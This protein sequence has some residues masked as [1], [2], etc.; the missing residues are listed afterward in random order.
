LSFVRGLAFSPDGRRL[1]SADDS[2]VRIW[3]TSTGKELLTLKG[4]LSFVRGLAFSPDGRRL[5]SGSLDRTVRIWDASTGKELLT[6]KGH[7]N[8]VNGVAFSPDSRRLASVSDQTVHVWDASTGRALLTLA[9]PGEVTGVAFSPDVRRLALGTKDQ[10]VLVWEVNTGKEL[11]VLKGHAGPVHGVTFSPDGQRLASASADRTARIWDVA[12]GQELLTLTGHTATLMG[13]AFSPD[14]RRLASAGDDKAVRVW[15]VS[16]VLGAVWRQRWLV[17]RVRSLF[18]ELGLLQEV[19]AALRKD[20]AVSEADHEFAM[21]VIEAY[22]ENPVQLNDIAWK[23]VKSRDAGKADYALALRQAEAA[24]RLVPEAGQ[25]LYTL[26]VAQYRAGHYAD[27]LA[28]LTK[29]EKLN[30]TK[31]G[32]LPSDLAFLAMTQH[33]LAKKDEA[34]ATLGRLREVIKQPR[35]AQDADAAGFLREAEELIEGKA[36][37]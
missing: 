24:V 19:L 1:A 15:E 36:A 28:T 32:S 13:I 26:S 23:V 6:L 17:S 34:K 9:H 31:G 7:T 3:D 25:Y 22:P 33:Q 10:T 16:P 18:E 4:H 37:D 30:A 21:Q 29:S 2:T 8:F 20:P 35:W 12:T 11:L 5:A 14:G 27:A